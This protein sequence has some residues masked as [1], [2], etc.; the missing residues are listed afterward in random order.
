MVCIIEPEELEMALRWAA[1]VRHRATDSR[2]DRG[3][4]AATRSLTSSMWRNVPCPPSPIEFLQ[5]E[6]GRLVLTMVDAFASRCLD[7]VIGGES[8]LQSLYEVTRARNTWQDDRVGCCYRRSSC[9]S[10]PS[11]EATRKSAR[12]GQAECYLA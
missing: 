6:I 9:T 10:W 4:E 2:H 11:N 8:L 1:I 3:H 7:L 5:A 12:E